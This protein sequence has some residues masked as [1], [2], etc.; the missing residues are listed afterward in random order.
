ALI[1]RTGHAAPLLGDPYVTV[2][3]DRVR[4]VL[5][6]ERLCLERCL[7]DQANGLSP[8]RYELDRLALG[9]EAVHAL[10]HVGKT[11]REQI[12]RRGGDPPLWQPHRHLIIPA[13]G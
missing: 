9:D 3:A 11:L 8:E 13:A 6:S 5:A 10:V 1:A 2:F 12:H 7:P 4:R